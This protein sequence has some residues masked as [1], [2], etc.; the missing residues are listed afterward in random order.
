L[1]R[2][3]RAISGRDVLSLALVRTP[4]TYRG[5]SGYYGANTAWAT[6]MTKRDADGR[7]LDA[8]ARTVRIVD[9]HILSGCL[10]KSTVGAGGAGIY[11]A[12]V[13][14]YGPRETIDTIFDMQQIGTNYIALHGFTTGV[15]DFYVS[16]ESRA[17]ITRIIE[18]TLTKARMITNKLD[19]GRI[20]P[21]I[22]KTVAQYY[23]EMQINAQRISDEF[24]EPIFASIADRETNGIFEMLTIGKGS[25]TFLV[26]MVGTVGLILIS[27]ERA[28]QNYSR[29]RTLPYFQRYDESP[30]SRG[31]A[32]SSFIQ[33]LSSTAGIF[34]SMV[35][36]T[37]IITRSLY[38]TVTGDQNR[39]S[40]KNLE[41][42][43]TNNHRMNMKGSYIV[44]FIY[45]GDYFDVR[46]VSNVTYGPAMISNGDL[47]R[48]YHYKPAGGE[49]ARAF[50]EEFAHIR[51]DRAQYRQIFKR[52]EDMSVRDKMSATIKMPFNIQRIAEGLWRVVVH[53]AKSQRATT[54][55]GDDDDAGRDDDAPDAPREVRSGPTGGLV[56]SRSSSGTGLVDKPDDASYAEIARL[57]AQFCAET[58][59][60][61]TNDVQ[62]EKH[63]PILDCMDD[64]TALLQMYIRSELSAQRVKTM[65]ARF[66]S[67]ST[68]ELGAHLDRIVDVVQFVR[69][70]LDDIRMHVKRALIDPGTPV[71]ILAS[72]SFSEPFTQDMLDS[73][74]TSAITGGNAGRTKMSAC[75]ELLKAYPVEKM[76]NAAMT[77]VLEDEYASSE[78]R[79]LDV[80]RRVEMLRFAHLVLR[81]HIFCEK[82]G[83][84]VHPK[85]VGE[86]EIF[87]AFARDNPAIMRDVS[88]LSP[89]CLRFEL[90]KSALV[91]KNIDV[92]TV[93]EMLRV[94][95][96]DLVLVY[97]LDR[98]PHVIIRAYLR[99]NA[100]K[101][102]TVH[103]SDV[104]DVDL[105]REKRAR[106]ASTTGDAD[107]KWIRRVIMATVLRGINGVVRARVGKIIRTHVDDDGK[108]VDSPPTFAVFTAGT[109]LASAVCVPGVVGEFSRTNAIQEIASTLGINAARY[110][111]IAAMHELVD[112]CSVKH[113]MIYADEMTRM[114]RVTPI[115]RNGVNARDVNNIALRAALAAPMQ[116]FSDAAFNTRRDV[117]TGMSGPLMYGA[118]PRVGTL[119]NTFAIDGEVVKKC[120]RDAR[121]TIE[122]L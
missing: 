59:Y 64:A 49:V 103:A 106:R 72:T 61:Y 23:E 56:E 98:A 30:E 66:M 25:L 84:P 119:Y 35:S 41:G 26:N 85:Y 53:T 71:G 120:A 67:E 114:G 75:R 18:Q 108:V 122:D 115:E 10:D 105:M 16:P 24:Y 90:N 1:F 4:I 34:N 3:R 46:Y 62:R 99:A 14:E 113:Y 109:N 92:T 81:S 97:T 52:L 95:Y 36:R 43:V 76:S 111:I 82:F 20:I 73:Y 48:D 88:D 117:I 42:I 38:T 37:D 33:G 65:L 45:G 112:K 102:F 101:T 11:Q 100:I 70:I 121:S 51:A 15:R 2:G 83:A 68:G 91:Q 7:D 27:G 96:P 78:E 57:V 5:T 44:S 29:A 39:G 40:V 21:P 9:G 55:S 89:W 63:A 60:L 107:I 50:E 104:L 54:V 79:A 22:D 6:Y 93:V 87:T 58:P 118:V 69:N 74:K 28:I 94:K 47:E 80:A 110:F 32:G 17:R 31:Y 13:H 19:E 86:R 8:D 77:L 116:A 12:L